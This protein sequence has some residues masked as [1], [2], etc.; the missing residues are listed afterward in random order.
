MNVQQGQGVPALISQACR[1]TLPWP[2]RREIASRT[3]DCFVPERGGPGASAGFSP[4]SSV[5][6]GRWG[7][8]RGMKG[9]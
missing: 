4:Q 6:T 7:D 5:Q 2:H 3:G 9:E 1:W 8:A